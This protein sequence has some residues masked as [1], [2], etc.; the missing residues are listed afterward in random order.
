M[1]PSWYQWTILLLIGSIC[2]N[3]LFLRAPSSCT[4][5]VLNYIQILDCLVIKYCN[6]IVNQSKAIMGFV[7]AVVNILKLE[8]L[9]FEIIFWFL[10]SLLSKS[11]FLW[12]SL[13]LVEEEVVEQLAGVLAISVG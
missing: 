11:S 6:F 5:Y 2:A 13:W 12:L 4:C 7:I 1:V 8:H 9:C 10:F 3:I